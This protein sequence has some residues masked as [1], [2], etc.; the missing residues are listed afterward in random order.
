M[1]VNGL[2]MPKKVVSSKLTTNVNSNVVDLIMKTRERRQLKLFWC[3][4]G[5]FQYIYYITVQFLFQILC[6]YLRGTISGWCFTSLPTEIIRKPNP[7]ITYLFKVNNRNTRTRCDIYSKLTIK[8]PE[9][10]QSRCFDVFI[11]NFKHIS[12]LVLV[13]LLL[14]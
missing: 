10:H 11:V 2:K 12:Q 9:R 5:N 4:I 6:N 13:F 1:L 8:T 3:F 14:T 7:A